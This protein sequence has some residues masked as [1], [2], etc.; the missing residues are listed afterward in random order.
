MMADRH[1]TTTLSGGLAGFAA[2][3][4]IVLASGLAPALGAPSESPAI[5]VNPKALE[6]VPLPQA[7][8]K[9]PQKP[10]QV[11]ALP[12]ANATST[13]TDTSKFAGRHERIVFQVNQDA[14]SAEAIEK[15]SALATDLTGNDERI[16][17]SAY[18]GKEGEALS[19]AN[20]LALKH[21]LLVRDYL[22]G[23]GIEESR[24][25]VR[26]LGPAQSGPQDRVDIAFLTR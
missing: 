3:I 6:A 21:A 19:D 1:R 8:P 7:K 10:S 14:L 23:K 25:L 4:A 2:A 15:L 9:E 16:E 18:A 12:K 26:A 22:V 17:L 5:E 20:R 24:V 13:Q 11:A